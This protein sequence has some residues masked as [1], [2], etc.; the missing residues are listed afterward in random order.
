[1]EPTNEDLHCII[2]IS[3]SVEPQNDEMLTKI[4]TTSQAWNFEHTITGILL[5][6]DGNFMQV[7]EG[8]DNEIQSLFE[9]IKIDKRHEDVYQVVGKEVK[10]R[11]F[12]KWSM[13][14]RTAD[15][16]FF[17]QV[18]IEAYNDPL[19]NRL[20]PDNPNADNS[21]LSLIKLFIAMNPIA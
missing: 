2:Y 7:L 18:H 5:Y 10:S 14:F 8:S 3:K 1:M 20:L 17:E 16:I 4:L 6:H 13:A 19:N 15:K 21:I 11:S 9:K 12:S